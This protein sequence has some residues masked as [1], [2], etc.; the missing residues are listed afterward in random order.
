MK[1]I[2]TTVIFAGLFAA[3]L[4]A[5][6]PPVNGENFLEL[7]SP[8]TLTEAASV[9]GGA[10]FLASPDS[11]IV[12]PA[13]TAGEQRTELNLGY[14]ALVSSNEA[15]NSKF[16]SAF[17]LGFLY[18]TKW[19][20][21]SAYLNGTFVPFQEMMLG[22]SVNAKVGL[23]KEVTEKL[24]VGLNLNTGIS[25]GSGTDW[26]LSGNLGFVYDWGNLAFMKDFRFGASVLN[27]GKNYTKVNLDGMYTSEEKP[28]LCGMFPMIGTV[29]AGAAATLFANDNIKTGASLDLTVPGFQNVIFDAGIQLMV[30]DML[31]LSVAE[32]INLRESIAGIANYIPSVS[33]AFTFT[34]DVKNSDY[35]ESHSWSESEMSASA[36]YKNMYGTI[37]AISAGVDLKLGMEDNVAPAI[38]L[39]QD[40]E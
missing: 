2:L 12:N 31:S 25:F 8:K 3:S 9:T 30:K 13:L 20:V 14:T 27:L 6:N 21:Y 36:A 29:K 15:N 39:W 40:E 18:P 26:A 1:K 19:Y 17:Q 23:S 34:L 33:L 7:S 28:E 4:A 32:K 38:E 11:L 35:F 16:G 10:L 37:N 24:D 22:N 5:Y